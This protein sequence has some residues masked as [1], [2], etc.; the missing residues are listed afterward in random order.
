MK[1]E[2]IYNMPFGKVYGLLINK[3][4]RKNRT[5]KEVI[6][7]TSWLLG[8]SEEEINNCLNSEISYG[9][10]FLKAPSLNMSYLNIRGSICDIKIEEIECVRLFNAVHSLC[11]VINKEAKENI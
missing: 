1:N 3:A 7:L 6:E 10:F 9:D 8:Y 5:Q 11:M 2:K 4:L